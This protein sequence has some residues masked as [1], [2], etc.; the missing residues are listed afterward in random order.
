MSYLE[1]ILTNNSIT[2]MVLN[3]TLHVG[4]D[5]FMC[6]AI[7]QYN[8]FSNLRSLTYSTIENDADIHYVKLICEPIDDSSGITH[9]LIKQVKIKSD[10]LSPED[11]SSYGSNKKVTIVTNVKTVFQC[12]PIR[13]VNGIDGKGYKVRCLK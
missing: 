2:A 8:P 5:L 12:M 7:M 10:Y 11:I 9:Y 4:S 3:S 1:E 6:N 13:D